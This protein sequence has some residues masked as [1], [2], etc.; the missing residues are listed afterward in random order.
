MSLVFVSSESFDGGALIMRRARQGDE[1]APSTI[2]ADF[3]IGDAPRTVTLR[4]DDPAELTNIGTELREDLDGRGPDGVNTHH[5][6]RVQQVGTFSIAVARAA[7]TVAI[8]RLV[9]A[10]GRAPRDR[11]FITREFGRARLVAS[12]SLLLE[13]AAAR[14]Q[15]QG[16]IVP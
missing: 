10:L 9:A 12:C 8:E 6:V 11:S 7:L 3:Y 14:G 13:Q 15:F 5:P 1:N 4:T 2:V 16:V